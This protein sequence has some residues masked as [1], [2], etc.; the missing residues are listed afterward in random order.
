MDEFTIIEKIKQQTYRNETLL[1]GIGDD[2]A[3]FTTNNKALVTAVDTFVENV[4]FTNDTLSPRQIGY[5][6]LAANLSDLAAMGALP[7]YYLVS[8]VI[9]KDV[10]ENV[11]TEIFAGMDDLAKQFHVDLIGGDTVSGR[12]LVISITVIGE[13][14]KE[15]ARYRDQA[16]PGDIIFVTGTLGDA[17][18][19]LALLLNE[20]DYSIG[21]NLRNALIKKHQQPIPRIE[22][23]RALSALKRV[24]LNDISDGI[25]N[26]LHEIASSSAVTLTIEAEKIPISEGLKQFPKD[27]QDEWKLFGG[28]DFELVGTV[29]KDDFPF[30]QQIGESLSV[31][32]TEI[33][34]VAYN[35]QRQGE[36]FIKKDGFIERLEKLGYIHR[37]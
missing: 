25:S 36:V 21:N 2:A 31:T 22:F 30:V 14:E 20:D 23:A 6:A 3:V 28:E 24:A 11:I 35:R 16:E 32:V 15:K 9:P 8:I 37:N 7:L 27:K 5:R 19:G 18:A 26:E 29:N 13:V 12:E 17:R 33:G 10:A 4:H 34:N 1:K